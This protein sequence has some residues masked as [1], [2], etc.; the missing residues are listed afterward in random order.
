MDELTIQ[1]VLYIA[2]IAVFVFGSI[3]F[4]AEIGKWLNRA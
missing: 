3:M 4:L 2:I 1:V